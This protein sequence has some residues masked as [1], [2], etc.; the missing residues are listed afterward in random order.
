MLIKNNINLFEKDSNKKSELEEFTS[1]HSKI[2]DKILLSDV[3]QDILVAHDS[4]R[5]M[6]NKPVYYN[7]CDLNNYD[8]V[9]ETIELIKEDYGVEITA[10]DVT[11]IVTDF[12]SMN[13]LGDKYG[14]S[15]DV[16]YHVKAVFR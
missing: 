9:N 2:E 10:T 5:K 7:R 14:V 8:H 11:N 15:E 12:D 1:L 16:V 4:I 6:L 13:S 3:E